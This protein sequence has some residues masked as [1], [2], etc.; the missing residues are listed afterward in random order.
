MTDRDRHAP[1][2][3]SNPGPL[4]APTGDAPPTAQ[5]DTAPR[6][7]GPPMSLSVGPRFPGR[8]TADHPPPSLDRGRVWLAR[9]FAGDFAFPALVPTPIPHAGRGPAEHDAVA[10]ALGC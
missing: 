1:R 5:Q 7:D 3:A 8:P 4:I 6:G 2:R 9:L 10:R